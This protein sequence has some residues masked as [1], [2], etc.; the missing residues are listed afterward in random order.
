MVTSAENLVQLHRHYLA[1]CS[2]VLIHYSGDNVPWISSKLKDLLKAPGFGRKHPIKAMAVMVQNGDKF[3]P[4]ISGLDIISI[5]KGT[6]AVNF[7][8]FLEKINQ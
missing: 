7:D 8:N 4:P 2:G 6:K 5:P 1:N 3:A